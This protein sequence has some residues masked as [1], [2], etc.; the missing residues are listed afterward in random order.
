MSGST[1]IFKKYLNAVFVETGSA[2]GGGIQQALDA[3]F[4][5]VYS[6]ELHNEPYQYCIE[7]FKNSSKVHIL[8]G[9]S[10]EV[11]CE[12][13]PKIDSQITFWLDGHDE[14]KYPIMEELECIKSHHIK[15]H[16]ILIDDLRMFDIEKH[17]LDIAI[18]ELKLLEIN[19]N[20]IFSFENGHVV[21]DILIAK[22]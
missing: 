16:T 17:G 8:L 10:K 9:N 4:E 18:I 2:Y 13:L 1:E 5:E 20:Y 11:L 14:D 22:L 3:G 21:N 7:M 19:H 15:T 6:I 12:L